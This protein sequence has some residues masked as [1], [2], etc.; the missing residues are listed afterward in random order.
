M[1][2]PGAPPELRA[3]A[4]PPPGTGEVR[5]AVAACALNFADLLMLEGHYQEQP[6]VPFVPGMEVA[7]TV[8]STGSGTH[9]PPPGARVLAYAGHGGL[10][11]EANVPAALCLPIPDALD[12]A[13]A[14]ALPVVYGTADLGLF[15]RG[16]L[17]AG[18]TVLVTGAAGGAGMTAVE[19]A[20][21]AG[22]TVIASCRG[23]AKAEAARAAGA[24]HVLDPDGTDDLKGALMALGGLDVIYDTVGGEALVQ[25]MRALRPEGRAVIVGFASGA[26]P[27]PKLNH[28]L[29]KNVEVIGFWWGGYARFAPKV[30]R[31][32]LDGLIARAARGEIAPHVGTTLPLP[33][34]MEGY[35]M[36]R[37][38]RS[39]GKVVVDCSSAP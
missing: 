16:R 38:G 28:L 20:A 4:L 12:F 30:V 27:R 33:R 3:M 36:L 19:L 9:A 34:A 10:A 37:D 17:R 18:E 23:A 31:A 14:A 8:L 22:A 6:A 15:R 29:V 26:V 7:G 5:L 32:S 1:S 13:T 35:A 24:A 2:A 11:R 39:T 25:A 21:R